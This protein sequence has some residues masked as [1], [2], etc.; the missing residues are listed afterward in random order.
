VFSVYAYCCFLCKMA[1]TVCCATAGTSDV[2]STPQET[3]TTTPTATTITINTAIRP[4]K[5]F[6]TSIPK[7]ATTTPVPK[8]TTTT[9]T[10]T[11]A[12]PRRALSAV[13]GIHIVVVIHTDR[14]QKYLGPFN[15]IKMRGWKMTCDWIKWRVY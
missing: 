5:T 11:T 4:R 1:L 13:T 6:T 9:P 12:R 2:E 8:K 15:A 7:K 14:H 10:T 3:T